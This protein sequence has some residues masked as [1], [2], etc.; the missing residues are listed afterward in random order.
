MLSRLMA[1]SESGGVWGMPFTDSRQA[2]ARSAGPRE[3]PVG[4]GARSNSKCSR[5][6]VNSSP[7]ASARATR[8]ASISGG[9]SMVT[10]ITG[11]LIREEFPQILEY[12][13]A[14][15]YWKYYSNSN[16]CVPGEELA[17]QARG[18]ISGGSCEFA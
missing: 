4:V 17:V 7:R 9:S 15:V 10:V 6:C 3:A 18:G 13:I 16:G 12:R 8:L 11:R 2:A 5:Y 14:L 1:S